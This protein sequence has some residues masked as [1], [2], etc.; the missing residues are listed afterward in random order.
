MCVCI[1]AETPICFKFVRLSVLLY[2]FLFPIRNF[3][4]IIQM[5]HYCTLCKHFL[6]C[7]F[8]VTSCGPRNI[9]V[10]L[11]LKIYLNGCYFC[12]QKAWHQSKKATQEETKC[13]LFSTQLY[14][15]NF[16]NLPN[17]CNMTLTVM[18]AI[19]SDVRNSRRHVGT[20]CLQRIEI[21]EPLRPFVL[22]LRHGCY[23]V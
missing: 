20:D 3:I 7:C 18:V 9:F 16:A 23:L 10:F 22:L 17:C 2:I 21:L 19:Q 6:A 1:A 4:N 11:N 5:L 12:H 13:S 14:P 8:Q 15:L